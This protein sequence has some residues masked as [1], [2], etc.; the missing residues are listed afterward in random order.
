MNVR[1]HISDTASPIVQRI[2]RE[3]GN[4]EKL[5]AL[6]ATGAEKATRDHISRQAGVRHKTASDLGAAPTGELAKAAG[7]VASDSDASGASVS[8]PS[9]LFRRAFQDVTIRPINSP[10]LTIPAAA[11]AY[12]KRAGELRRQGWKIFRP[13]KSKVLM[14]Y[15][16]KGTP[17]PLYFLAA[18]VNQRQDRTLLPSNDEFAKVA[19]EAATLYSQT[20]MR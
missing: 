1:I 2:V 8:V 12:G 6:I 13:G 10:Y 14:G 16:G 19:G 3:L 18:S 17:I 15:L 9:Y 20:L 4:P 11:P 5:H 7:R